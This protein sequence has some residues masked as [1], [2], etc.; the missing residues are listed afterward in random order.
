MLER[1]DTCPCVVCARNATSV[2]SAR[3]AFPPGAS[4]GEVA[5]IVYWVDGALGGMAAGHHSK[6]LCEHLAEEH[7]VDA[8]FVDSLEH[9]AARE[10]HA[11]MPG[12]G[13]HLIRL[14]RAQ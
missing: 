5:S 7:F 12:L 1:P 6:P 9:S 3:G 11:V 13:L 4:T 14:R 10:T 2:G 8:A